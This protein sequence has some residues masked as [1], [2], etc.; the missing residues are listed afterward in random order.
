MSSQVGCSDMDQ[1]PAEGDE[2]RRRT[3][4]PR[5]WR[6]AI[7]RALLVPWIVLAPL[8]ALAPTA[9][10]RFNL[11]LN[12]GLY[13][14]N[15]LWIV[16]DNFASVNH[17]LELGNFRPLG[18]CLE[19]ALDLAAF[20]LTD[21]LGLPANVSLRLIS[22]AVASVLSVAILLLAETF[23]ARERVFA[24]RPTVFS[25]AIPFAVGTGLVAAGFTSTA[26][27]FGA[28]YMMSATVVLGVTAA[29]LWAAPGSSKPIGV[30]WKMICLLLVGAALASFN[31]IGYF[32]LPL[33]TIA[34]LLRGRFV[35]GQRWSGVWS[36]AGMRIVGWMWLGFVPVF[37]VTRAIIW[38]HCHS[39]GCYEGS[40]IV[41]SSD[42]L[43]ALPN[44]LLSW[45][46]PLM[47]H[48]AGE[49]GGHTVLV[50]LLPLVAA[51]ML[52]FLAWSAIRDL[53]VLAAVDRVRS[54]ALAGL[55][56]S[57]LVLGAVLAAL[58]GQVQ[59][60]STAGDWGVGWRDSAVTPF[61]GGV[62]LI[63]VVAGLVATHR[64]RRRILAG[65]VVVL[66]LAAVA[67]TTT[68]D[69]FKNAVSG[70]PELVLANH[71]A[72]EIADFDKSPAGNDRRCDLRRQFYILN[73][74]PLARQRFDGGLNAAAMQLAGVPFCT[75]T[76]Q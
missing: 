64:R 8:V 76:G 68:N 45:L 27:L 33:A 9:D 38:G 75:R 60:F 30:G 48:A 31:E 51:V 73:Q 61:A 66:A 23:L 24:N 46:P 13:R 47:W 50:G 69:R 42:L 58:S 71:V 43:I 6:R 17:Y 55:A 19:V 34:V 57:L 32:A 44:R 7:V 26:V 63:G 40:D 10:H 56:A 11:Y 21:L 25:A 41:L 1:K 20:L 53:R 29:V 14:E 59:K 72:L 3:S 2:D 28:L 36:G 39:G 4:N 18:R 70:Q 49:T 15:P 12:G 52:G 37:L 54:F 5:L 62:L 22:F 67:S 74:V 35:L 65:L 16:W